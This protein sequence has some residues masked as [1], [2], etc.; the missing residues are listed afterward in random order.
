MFGDIVDD[1]RALQGLADQ[2]KIDVYEGDK[3][4]K[5]ETVPTGEKVMLQEPDVEE[6]IVIEKPAPTKPKQSTEKTPVEQL[7]PV[8]ETNKRVLPMAGEPN[9]LP[10]SIEVTPHADGNMTTREPGVNPAG[11]TSGH[12]PGTGSEMTY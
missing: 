4:L 8:P 12:L 5:S 3:L 7:L 9:T 11:K 10:E 1:Q 6:H 2:H